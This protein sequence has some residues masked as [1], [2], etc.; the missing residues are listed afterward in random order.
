MYTLVL[1]G[2]SERANPGD[3]SHLQRA[4]RLSRLLAALQ[5]HGRQYVRRQIQQLRRQRWSDG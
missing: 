1:S 3:P 5:Y 4:A 2:R